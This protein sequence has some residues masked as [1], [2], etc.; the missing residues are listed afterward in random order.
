MFLIEF[1]NIEATKNVSGFGYNYDS[2]RYE[3]DGGGF[4]T[5]HNYFLN[6][7]LLNKDAMDAL[8]ERMV[9]TWRQFYH[10]FE[11]T[12]IEANDQGLPMP[13]M[14]VEMFRTIF[15]KIDAK[16]FTSDTLPEMI[17]PLIFENEPA[18]AVHWTDRYGEDNSLNHLNH[19]DS[20]WWVVDIKDRGRWSLVELEMGQVTGGIKKP[21]QVSDVATIAR[22]EKNPRRYGYG[23]PEL[24]ID[25]YTFEEDLP[26]PVLEAIKLNREQFK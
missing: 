9:N 21:L 14:L 10:L 11:Y 20:G 22:H 1:K 7:H 16:Q 3:T 4:S 13:D 17:V 19:L 2:N 24:V 5:Y 15:P 18:I 8:K 25:K 26:L 12:T 6:L 23:R